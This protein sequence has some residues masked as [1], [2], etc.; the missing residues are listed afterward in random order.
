[1][2]DAR[3]SPPADERLRQ[4][5]DRTMAAALAVSGASAGR[6]C[7]DLVRSLASILGTD[8]ALIGEFIDPGRT[9]MRTL[10]VWYDGRHLQNFD[11]DVAHSPCRHIVGRDSRL[12]AAGVHGEFAPGTLF[13]E[14]GFD[15]YAGYSLFDDNDEQI[16]L[17]VALGRRPLADP[18]LTE[19]LM[20]IFAVRAGAELQRRRAAAALQVSETSYRAIFEAAQDAMFVHDWDTGALVDVNPRAGEVYGYTREEMLRL[21]VAELSS[22][23]PPYTLDEAVRHIEAAKSGRTVRFEWHRRNKDGTLHWDEVVL[24]PVQLGGVPRIL[25]VT[26]EITERK[27]AEQALR[28]S[29]ARLRATVDSALDCVLVVD[30][31]GRVVEFNPAAEATFGR[32]RADVIGCEMAELLI[33]PR[34]R[35]AHRAGMRRAQAGGAHR[36]VGRRVEMAAMR[37]DG[38][39]F[40]VEMAIAQVES[41]EGPLYVGFLRDITERKRTDQALRD[42]EALYRGLFNAS[43]DAMVLRDADFRV[44]DVN[45]SYT[46][47]SGYSREETIGIDRLLT[48][49][50]AENR[51]WRAAH[52]RMLAGEQL[53]FE[54]AA[55]RKDGTPYEA[56]VRGMPVS[57]NE[58]PHV[59]YVTRDVTERRQA[60]RALAASEE[61]Y[62]GIFNASAD[63]LVLWNSEL[64][65]V[66]VNPAYLR[67]YRQRREDVV[68][69]GYPAHYPKEY[70][71]T[72]Q[73]LI[74]RALA[75]ETCEL[76]TQSY[77]GDGEL[78]EVEWRVVP[79]LHRGEPHALAIARDITERKQAEAALKLREEQY[80][81]I[82]DGS[83][84]AVVLWNE[85]IRIVDVNRAFTEM[86]GFSREEVLGATLDSRMAADEVARRVACIRAALEGR[87]GVLETETIGK[88]GQS[89][90]VELRYLPITHVGKPHVLAIARDITERRAAEAALRA[91]EEQYRAIFNA[92]ADALVLWDGN[93]RRV[94]VN[95][96]YERTYGWS[97]AEVIGRGYEHLQYP[98]EYARPRYE[99]VRRAL[100]GET[101]RAELEAVRKDGGRILTEVHAIPFRHRGEPH[102]LAIARDITERKAAEAAL[103]ASEEQYRSIFEVATD[104]LQLL[105]AQCQVV[106]VNPAYERMY[107][108]RRAEV[109]GK[110]IADLVPP[111]FRA[112]RLALVRRALAGEVVEVQSTG[113]RSDGSAFDLEVRTIPFQHRGQPHVLGIARDITER[114]RAEERLRASEEQYR[115]IFSASADAMVLRDEHL[116]V[117]DVNPA[118]LALVQRP[119][120]EIVGRVHPA[121]VIAPERDAAEEMLRSALAG[122]PGKLE[123]QTVSADGVR[124][125]VEVRAVPMQYQGRPHVLAIARDVTAE[126]RA[127]RESRRLETQLRQAQKMEAIG[128]LTGG[129][130]HDFNNIL[131]SVMGYVVLAEERAANDGDA[132]AVEYLGQALASCRRARDLIQ[133]M[134]TFSRGGR[135]EPRAL[136]L[137]ALAHDALPM[138]R[139]SLP[140]TLQLTLDC[141]PQTPPAWTDEVQAHQVLLNLVI[142]ARD[143]M[144]GVGEIRITVRLCQVA[145]SSCSSCRHTLA[146]D[147]VELAVADRGGGI[148]PQVLDRI[149]DP[150]FTTKAPGK[151]SGMG[152]SMVHGIAHEHGGHVL[153]DNMPGVGAVF[154]VLW[155]ASAAPAQAPAPATSGRRRRRLQGRALVIDDE[156]AVLGAMREMMCLWGLQVDA[157]THAEAAQ[158][159][160]EAAPDAYDLVVTDL[161]MPQCSG[162][163]LAARLRARRRV[164]ILL[165]SGFV[166]ERSLAAAREL[167]LDAVLHKP[168]EAEQLRAAVEAALAA[169]AAAQS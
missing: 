92:S 13:A 97:R 131:A 54:F 17:I 119:R 100:A 142:N 87:E 122:R 96:A 99:L 158:A 29:E 15:A 48:V 168:V 126:R 63:A 39:E 98:A 110:G 31:E 76:Q 36:M 26:R 107:G 161:A 11:Y 95:P 25:A 77:R 72:R 38:G 14:Q 73:R 164:P 141:A 113:F 12:V 109:V 143:A 103:R 67:I 6:V 2:N 165:V 46:A 139:A 132:K 86:Y 152:L 44:V 157:H 4:V 10:A 56:E 1:M 55:R 64:R 121:F 94:D 57:W 43:A 83:A 69:F 60:E 150:F 21:S 16:G 74:R 88:S 117:V 153:V 20:K 71:E 49:G 51:Q 5:L 118:F 112:E 81:V 130:A 41:P 138:L 61:Q 169:G 84:D 128:Q 50:E 47:M 53:R 22:N 58:R 136:D 106:D 75:G 90:F 27:M 159:A 115:A 32:R 85:D 133:Q 82:F 166:D 127:E 80:R 35:E 160:F 105:D 45:P 154:R 123:V 129:I 52:Q 24:Q 151:G 135:G 42:S 30:A 91:S 40:P 93:Y 108:R 162:L 145:G 102:V 59:L 3:G 149:F 140:S 34:L 37:A 68:G 18:E 65:V 163:E 70:V 9:R 89:F 125:E 19:A 7:E 148:P 8:A 114:K 137:A 79:V 147:Y 33:P 111:D 167:G 146:G 144:A 101:C 116:R 62:R 124:R 156:P 28:A 78:F 104:S 134:L 66:D 120:E 155:P 23:V